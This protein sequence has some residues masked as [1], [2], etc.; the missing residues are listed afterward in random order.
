MSEDQ[1]EIEK[2]A[3]EEEMEL[4]NPDHYL[5]YSDP[6]FL[7]NEAPKA[8]A[9]AFA[10][11]RQVPVIVVLTLAKFEDIQERMIWEKMNIPNLS[12][13]CVDWAG[14]HSNVPFIK[15]KWREAVKERHDKVKAS[16][17]REYAKGTGKNPP[18]QNQEL[19]PPVQ[20]LLQ[21][22]L[23]DLL[24]KMQGRN[25]DDGPFVMVFGPTPEE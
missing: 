19:P 15:N 21:D 13:V 20:N 2:K 4:D 8:S 18:V 10:Q 9:L 1:V 11:E 7:I 23:Q 16:L 5:F 6:V 14:D 25:D 24:Q 22:L 12:Y 17:V 3:K